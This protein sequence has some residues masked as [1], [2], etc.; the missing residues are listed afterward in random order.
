QASRDRRNLVL[1]NMHR[2]GVIKTKTEVERLKA[3]P[4]EVNSAPQKATIAPY[5]VD[6]V[7]S[8]M[9]HEDQMEDARDLAEKAYQVVSTVD[10]NMQRICEEEMAK[11]LRIVEEASEAQKEG[12]LSS[13]EPL[14][15]GR[16]RLARITEV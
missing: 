1:E 8:H 12:R 10:L 4:I 5:F 16:R 14:A 9:V 15:V 3:L 11:G 7:A 13:E 2:T 6:F